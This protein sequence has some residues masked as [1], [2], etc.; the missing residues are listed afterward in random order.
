MSINAWMPSY[1]A[2]RHE[3]AIRAPPDIVYDALFSIDV[4]RHALVRA[5]LGLRALPAGLTQLGQ[6]S[7]AIPPTALRSPSRLWYSAVSSSSKSKRHG[8]RARTHAAFG[9]PA[10]RNKD[11]NGGHRGCEH[12]AQL[13]AKS[14]VSVLSPRKLGPNAAHGFIPRLRTVEDEEKRATKESAFQGSGR[15]TARCDGRMRRMGASAMRS[16]CADSDF[17]R[18]LARLSDRRGLQLL[19]KSRRARGMV[20]YTRGRSLSARPL[21]GGRRD[22]PSR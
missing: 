8:S 4:G 18:A 2:E 17:P 13:L 1:F 16:V 20:G 9:S 11:G 22:E 12:L 14:R 3:T 6:G 7:P 5:L 15:R 10:H 21:G 19:A